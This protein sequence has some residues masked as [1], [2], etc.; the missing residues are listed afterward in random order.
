MA[1]V[2]KLL[3]H[4][5]YREDFK[6]ASALRKVYKENY[7]NV[8]TTGCYDN[9]WL[10]PC[11]LCKLSTASYGWILCILPCFTYS[12]CRARH[13]RSC[14]SEPDSSATDHSN[15]KER[16]HLVKMDKIILDICVPD[17]Q[18][19]FRLEELYI[20]MLQNLPVIQKCD[21]DRMCNSYAGNGGNCY[22]HEIYCHREECV[23][24]G[25]KFYRK[26]KFGSTPIIYLLVLN[27]S[28]F[29]D[30]MHDVEEEKDILKMILRG[31]SH[32][33]DEIKKMFGLLQKRKTNIAMVFVGFPT[34]LK[35]KEK[36]AIHLLL[37]FMRKLEIRIAA[38]YGYGVS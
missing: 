29:T 23:D 16:E 4:I 6:F 7:Q 11:W 35:S 38:K 13:P 22:R 24:N 27:W 12:C 26:L 34:A 28:Y 30:N 21:F 1:A 17:I 33:D 14:G 37:R 32:S 25:H 8:P 9:I 20:N 31:N 15:N 19:N 2:V 5:K 3:E 36:E 10:S 18:N